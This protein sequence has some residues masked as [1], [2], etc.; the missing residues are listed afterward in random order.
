ML[1]IH[2]PHAPT[3]SWSD[4]FIHIATIAVG[5]LLALGL[6]QGVEAV[7]RHHE[8]VDLLED[9]KQENLSRADQLRTTN[10]SVSV[11][12]KR[13][14]NI[15]HAALA[16]PLSNG[17]ITITVP[18]EPTKATNGVERPASAVLSA[19]TSSGLVSVLSRQEIERWEQVDYLAQLGQHDFEATQADFR[20]IDAVCEHLGTPLVAGSTVHMSVAG[21]DE[22]TRA[23]GVMLVSLATLRS[24][25]EKTIAA[26]GS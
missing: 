10:D 5:L 16:A 15:L 20:A 2:P 6:E 9:L 24:D 26:G 12:E 13:T 22:L 3:H 17:T 11:V 1:D 21:R 19:A 8:R 23:L 18:A 7:H 25:N 14:G 4:F